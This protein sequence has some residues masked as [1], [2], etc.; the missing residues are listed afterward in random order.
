MR[1]GSPRWL[2]APAAA[3]LVTGLL[4]GFATV[5]F[6]ATTASPSASPSL[7]GDPAKGQQVFASAGCATCHGSALTGGVGPP[8]HPIKNLGDT[9]DPLD[10]QYLITTITNGKSGVGGYGAMLP[11]GGANLTDQDIRDLAAYIISENLKVGPAPYSPG[12]L[13]KSTIAWV[14]IG[15]LAMLAL[16]YLLSRYNMRWI[17]FKSRRNA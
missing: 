16:T 14:T 4:I 3:F 10:P 2:T 11:K 15:T 9:K 6:A 8:L 1:L 17:A 13:A 5:A 12:D 7:P